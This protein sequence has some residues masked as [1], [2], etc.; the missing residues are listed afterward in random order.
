MQGLGLRIQELGFR[1][2]AS[3]VRSDYMNPLRYQGLGSRL[4]KKHCLV[5]IKLFEEP[6]SQPTQR[7]LHP[8]PLNPLNS[9]NPELPKP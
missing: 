9:L 5:T 6:D 7:P 1:E 2:A 4:M 3:F 8:K